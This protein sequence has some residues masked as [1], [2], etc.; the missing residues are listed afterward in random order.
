MKKTTV[1]FLIFLILG[2]AIFLRVYKIDSNY[3]FTGELGKE[4]LYT[5]QYSLLKTLPFSG[6]AT[7]HEWLSYGPLYYWVMIPI[8]NIFSGDPYILFWSSLIISV[9]ALVV[10]FLVFK[11]I[12]NTEVAIVST[13]IQAVSPL[14]I[15]QT[16][17][18][19][20]HVFFWI[21]IPVFIYLI[22]K[23]WE[24]NKKYWF[25]VGLVFGVMFSFHFSQIPFL[26]IP[27]LLYYIKK[28]MYQKLDLFK[29]F[30]GVALPNISLLWHN[31]S[32]IAWLPYRVATSAGRDIFATIGAF[33]EFLGKI[34]FWD[35]KLWFLASI[36]I[37]Y[38]FVIYSYKNYKKITKDFLSFIFIT[39]IGVTFLANILHNVPPIHYFLP[40]FTIVPVFISTYLVKNTKLMFFVLPIFIFNLMSFNK[41]SLFYINIPKPDFK[42]GLIPYST[43]Q[44]IAKYIVKN[45]GGKDIGIKRI[46][47]Y[48]YFPENYSQNYKYLILYYG[49]NVVDSSN[50]VY[51]I[52]EDEVSGQINV[53]K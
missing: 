45:A 40:I 30:L 39:S 43:Q 23:I 1:L 32:L 33:N 17:L 10:N 42:I 52:V 49:G 13:L 5:R 7:S 12:I 2:I 50:N 35:S 8:F 46:G 4:L 27:L 37:I 14:F 53:Q 20:L 9:L 24:G 21:F 11:K 47:P 48:D 41:D 16:R 31:K 22:H 36:V 51:T 6:M 19:K 38:L 3:Y 44:N 26:L 34:F 29:F 18:S 28:D 25:W 15:W